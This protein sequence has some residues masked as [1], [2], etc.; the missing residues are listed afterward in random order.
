MTDAAGLHPIVER[1]ADIL[2]KAREELE[3][4]SSQTEALYQ[5][6][7]AQWLEKKRALESSQD[8]DGEGSVSTSDEES[9]LRQ[10]C[11]QLDH[12]L[13]R[14]RRISYKLERLLR[15]NE[16]DEDYLKDSGEEFDP[17]DW[18][19][20]LAPIR[21]VQSQEEERQRIARDLQE[22]VGQLL[23][24]AVF[25]LEYH[26]RAAENNLQIGREGL[27]SLKEELREGL[28]EVRWLISELRPPPLLGDLGLARSLK[29]YAQKYATH[30]GFEIDLELDG[31]EEQLPGIM[32]LTIFRII[33]ESLINIRKHAGATQIAVHSRR[34]GDRLVFTIEDN[35]R[36]FAPDLLVHGQAGGLGLINMRDRAALLGGRLQVFKRHEGGVRV[37]LSVPYPFDP[38]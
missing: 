15:R 12:H 3:L 26:D 5:D 7:L 22:R 32:E 1:A 34:E 8:L 14:L 36:G 19:K 23:A 37:I 21:I 29:R 24:N 38:R 9:T 13:T 33:Q 28:D 30:F 4:I 11:A 18:G 17:L 16:D 2:Q 10:Q 31:L 27:L 20:A 6:H 35:G 25:E